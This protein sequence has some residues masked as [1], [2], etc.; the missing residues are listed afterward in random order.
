MRIRSVK[1]LLLLLFP[2][3]SFFIAITTAAQADVYA[4]SF[5]Q[6]KV[7]VEQALKDLQVSSGQKLPILEGFVGPTEQPL[8]RYERGFYQFSVNLVPANG[9]ATVVTLKAKITAWYA[10]RDVA[11]SG[12]QV[13]PSNGRLEL[14]MLDRLEEKLTGKPRNSAARGPS[15]TQ[16]PLPKLDLSTVPGISGTTVIRDSAPT[17]DE[18]AELRAQ[19]IAREK[20]VQQLTTELQNLQEI[21]KTQAHPQNLVIVGKSGTPVFAKNTVGSRVLFQASQN[22]E[23][24]FLDSDDDWVHVSISG[25]SRGYLQRDAVLF[26]DFLA[27][28]LQSPSPIDPS[29][30]FLSFRIEREEIATFPGDWPDLRGKTVKIYTVLLASTNPK[31][32]GPSMRLN[33]ALALFQKGLKEVSTANP[34]PEGVVVIFDSPDGGIVAATLSEIQKVVTRSV[35]RD[36]FWSESYLDP[37]EAFRPTAK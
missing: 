12:Y 16:T 29:G 30:K 36:T 4:R 10:D 5:S 31:E 1:I 18:V 25:D 27:S 8:D 19:R 9:G 7:A 23:F 21:Q 17:A 11:K 15:G 20:R 35:P 24:E 2:F 28:K 34:A 32:T 22:D 14:D 37:M 13:L 6:P 3:C 33:Y 26:S